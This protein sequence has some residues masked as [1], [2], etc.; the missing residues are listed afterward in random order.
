MSVYERRF[1]L[2]LFVNEAEAKKEA[3]VEQRNKVKSTGKG[4]RSTTISGDVLKAKIKSG[5]IPNE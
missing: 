3:V 5:E 2:R 1:F 4:T